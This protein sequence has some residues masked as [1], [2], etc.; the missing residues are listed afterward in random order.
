MKKNSEC[1]TINEKKMNRGAVAGE[2]VCE[3]I[4][5]EIKHF[6]L[7]VLDYENIAVSVPC[8]VLSA[9][10]SEGIS[11]EPYFSSNASKLLTFLERGAEFTAEFEVDTVMLSMDNLLLRI[12]GVSANAVLLVNGAPVIGIEHAHVGYEIDIKSRIVLGKNT[13]SL[14]FAPRSHENVAQLCDAAIFAP[15]ELVS[16]N[17][18]TIDKVIV[19]QDFDGG[20]IKLSINMTTKG[21][22][23]RP[24]AVAVLQSPSGSV[25]Y[26]TLS[27]GRGDITV[28]SPNLWRPGKHR[29]HRLYH[30][31][32][33]LYSDTELIDT[34]EI[35][36][37]LR[38]LQISDD[39][40]LI[41]SGER[42]YPTAV[43]Y[44]ATDLI[45][46]RATEARVQLML[47]R[48]LDS[49]V[50]MIY[51]DS[52]DTYPSDRF[53]SICDEL[54][55]ALD[56]KMIFPGYPESAV[57]K[58]LMQR[59]IPRSLAR[60]IN[61]PSVFILSG[62]GELSR[63]V[64]SEMRSLV[65][66]AIYSE[67][68]FA[69]HDVTPSLPTE[70]TMRAYFREDDRNL[71]AP[72]LTDRSPGASEKIIR[73]AANGYR[74]PHSFGEWSYLSG[75][76]S[77]TQAVAALLR[78]RSCKCG[79]GALISDLTEYAPGISPSLLDYSER[80][81]A[82]YY[83]VARSAIPVSVYA[84][85]EGTKI[86]F[87]AINTETKVC[88]SRL[89]YAIIANDNRTVVRDSIAFEVDPQSTSLIYEYDAAEVVS[90]HECEYYLYC[91]AT[92]AAGTHSKQTLHFVSPSRFILKKPSIIA[93]VSGTG[94]EYTLTLYSDVYAEAVEVWFDGDEDVVLEDNFFDITSPVPVRIRM[95]T[96]RPTAVETL[97]RELRIRSMY[98]VGR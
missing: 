18:A 17:K 63:Q 94:C 97:K 5:K 2:E 12:D 22:N 47:R 45:R 8:S 88:K 87:Y 70:Y 54:G 82:A 3:V 44:T 41:L 72:A 76:I 53:M 59:D 96:E 26:C 9:L 36:L 49:G 90:G 91:Y 39:G 6:K 29:P 24:R 84:T 20:N 21:Y 65:P 15:M 50:D 10:V 27:G 16:Y 4:K 30:L 56:V 42:Y 23:S 52:L 83:Y 35:R 51:V 75:I 38:T 7:K 71:A 57:G 80:L 79:I 66:G 13:V 60:F 43:R 64:V 85:S 77:A 46:P 37:G 74:I 67:L 32:V 73:A 34:S 92:D 68:P 93:D 86:S 98:D 28:N 48:L 62:A 55:I 69:P 89:T 1:V 33:N 95:T 31:T 81:K 14:R 78:S 25:S 40:S 19:S 11:P 61:H 58:E